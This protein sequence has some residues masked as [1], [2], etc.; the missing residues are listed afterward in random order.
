MADHQEQQACEAN[1]V[2]SQGI[3]PWLVWQIHIDRPLRRHSKTNWKTNNYEPYIHPQ[4]T[5]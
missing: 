5:I 4:W 3:P 2:D 1:T